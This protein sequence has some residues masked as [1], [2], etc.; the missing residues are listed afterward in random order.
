MPAIKARQIFKS[1]G[2]GPL[3]RSRAERKLLV[4]KSPV[5]NA[6]TLSSFALS[7]TLHNIS[8]TFAW[9]G[10]QVSCYSIASDYKLLS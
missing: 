8:Y 10:Y 9:R 1:R 2:H 5:G 7:R 3:L 4:A 6:I